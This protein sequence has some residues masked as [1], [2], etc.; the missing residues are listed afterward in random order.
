MSEKIKLKY[1]FRILQFNKEEHS[2]IVRYYTD[3]LTEEMLC[4]S[5]DEKGRI[6]YHE[7]GYPLSCR[8]DYN[9]NIY[10][11]LNPTEE[12]IIQLIKDSVPDKWLYLKEC[13]I[14]NKTTNLSKFENIIGKQYEIE[15]MIKNTNI[16]ITKELTPLEI[17]ETGAGMNLDCFKELLKLSGIKEL[18]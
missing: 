8:S 18:N 10:D 14:N 3:I 6:L 15:S 5:F 11:N 16:E 7:N 1:K 12:E 4:N 9:I 2:V 17:L 13:I